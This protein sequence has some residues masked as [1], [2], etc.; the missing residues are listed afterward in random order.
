LWLTFEVVLEL[1][2]MNP[3][4]S[5]PESRRLCDLSRHELAEW[6]RESAEPRFRADQIFHWLYRRHVTDVDA[7][8]D[9]PATLRVAI[10]KR[11][12]VLSSRV[13]RSRTTLDDTEKLLLEF[14]DGCAVECVL[15]REGP[16]RTV[17]LSTQIGCAM[18]CAFCASGLLGWKRNLSRG[19]ILEQVLQLGHRLG[20]DE[21]FTN[22]VIMGMGEPLAN[23]TELLPALDVLRDAKGLAFS[24]RRITISTVGLPDKIRELA[25]VGI[26]YN[27]AVSLHAPNDRLRNELVRGNARIGIEAILLAAD[28]FFERTGRRVSYE[29]V[30]L[31]NV[32][33]RPEH[34]RQLAELLRRRIAHV[35]LIPMNAVAGL[36]FQAPQHAQ[37]TRFADI[38]EHNGITVTVR[39]R[40]GANIDAACGQLRLRHSVVP[41]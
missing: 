5:V 22:V 31:K 40:K 41:G 21:Q 23:L 30:L 20:P 15:M 3:T 8:S 13:V 28:A 38:L 16:R 24:P 17:C 27:L 1:C 4:P 12:D 9:L 19:E 26:P 39:K 36:A 11:F 18:G 14:P 10:Q 37:T 32:N 2:A 35:N 33:D 29:Y 34:A 7:M 25:E 6:C